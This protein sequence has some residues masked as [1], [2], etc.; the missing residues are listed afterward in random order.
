M[1]KKDTSSEKQP[2]ITK[3]NK[4]NGK[5]KQEWT[6]IALKVI[7]ILFIIVWFCMPNTYI[8]DGEYTVTKLGLLRVFHYVAL[9]YMVRLYLTR[10]GF[11]IHDSTKYMIGLSSAISLDIIFRTFGFIRSAQLVT[12]WWIW[13]LVLALLYLAIYFL[14]T[15]AYDVTFED[16]T[17]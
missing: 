1:K 6:L 2:K 14:D 5:Q 9:Y 8:K 7:A 13:G 10:I 11:F 17:R 12:R 4:K 16:T 3:Q 15:V